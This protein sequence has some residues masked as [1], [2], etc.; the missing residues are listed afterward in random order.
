MLH[1]WAHNHYYYSIKYWRNWWHKLLSRSI[2]ITSLYNLIEFASVCMFITKMGKKATLT[3]PEKDFFGKHLHYLLLTHLYF[4]KKW[5][6]KSL[7]FNR[8]GK[9][10]SISQRISNLKNTHIGAHQP[11]IRAPIYWPSSNVWIGSSIHRSVH[12]SEF[13]CIDSDPMNGF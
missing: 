8:E 12:T 2:E 13:Q 9:N 7:T 6:K 11:Y 3:L 1:A 10:V 5:S 4:R